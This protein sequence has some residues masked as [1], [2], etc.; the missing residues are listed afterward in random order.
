MTSRKPET[1]SYRR[2][3]EQKTDYTKRM[4]L[5][6]SRKP[7]VVV[8]ITNKHIIAQLVEFTTSGDKVL[9]GVNSSDL[10][11]QGWLYSCKNIPA[12]YLTGLLLGKAAQKKGY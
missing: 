1:V 4:Q 5:L 8:R 9:V 12:A 2:K 10:K 7:R 11:E 3:R 6:V